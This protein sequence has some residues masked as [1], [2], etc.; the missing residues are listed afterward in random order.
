MIQFLAVFMQASE[1]A[2]LELAVFFNGSLES[3]R[4]D[5][6]IQSQLEARSKIN[7]VSFS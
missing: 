6:W 4:K 3:S 7:N 1:A 2:G 5:D